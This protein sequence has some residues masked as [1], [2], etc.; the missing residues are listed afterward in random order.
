MSAGVIK[1]KHRLSKQEWRQVA[2][3]LLFVSPWLIGFLAWT[4]YPL[5]PS[6]YYSLTRYDLLRPP[7]FIGLKNYVDLLTTDPHF[8]VVIPNTLYYVG[9]GTP[10]AVITAFL[11]AQL[12]NGRIVGR[13]V[14]RAIFYFPSIVPATVIAMVWSYLLNPQYGA[15]NAVLKAAGLKTIPF[16]SNPTLAKPML[17]IIGMWASGYA[18]ILFLAALQDVPRD[19][20]EAAI[21][22]GANAVHRFFY[23]TIPYCSPVILF[24]LVTGFIYGFQ[25]FTLPWLLTGG[26]PVQSTE[27]YALHLFRNAFRYL[28]MG[29]A[30]AM[31]W[32]LFVIIVAFTFVLFK[33]SS[34]VVYYADSGE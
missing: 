3:G 19:L 15:I 10:L 16:L 28:R 4:I 21:M 7:V 5:L 20:Y 6:A 30:S 1:Q 2:K 24:T 26:G 29:K 12:L 14:F 17:I 31:A 9:L 23:V 11:L 18:M 33:S 27:F 22:D 34:R 13:P 32:I 8:K 25:D